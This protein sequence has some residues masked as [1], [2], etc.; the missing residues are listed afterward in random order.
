MRI[1]LPSALSC[2]HCA[3]RKA[4][5]HTHCQTL[6]KDRRDQPPPALAEGRPNR[7]FPVSRFG[8]DQERLTTL[9]QAIS[10]RNPTA[11]SSIHNVASMSPIT[12]VRSGVIVAAVTVD[13]GLMSERAVRVN[14]TL[15]SRL[16][17]LIDRVAKRT[18]GGRSGLLTTA[19]LAYLGRGRP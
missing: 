18:K 3:R 13:D 11:P 15:P 1:P 6:D 5:G 8:T 4:A 10:S 19:V 7:H 12:H 16:L 17:A 9:A 14:V 2:G